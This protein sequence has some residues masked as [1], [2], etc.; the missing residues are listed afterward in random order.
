MGNPLLDI[1]AECDDKLYEKYGIKPADA[2][3]A[4]EKHM[5]IYAE[6]VAK[7]D[8]QYLAGG[9]TQNSIRV[10]QW[11]LPE[12]P[13]STAYMGCVGKDANAEQMKECCKKDGVNAVYM[14]D[15]A[16]PTGCC[17]VCI[18]GTERSMVTNLQAANNYKVD[19][20]KENW[21]VVE[22]A[23]I[24]YSAGF[25]VTVS[26][27]TI[28]EVS[29]HASENGKTYCFNLAAPFIMQV[30]PFKEVVMKTMPYIDFLFGNESEALVF[31]E[32]EGW[33]E[34]DIAEIA[35]KLSLLPKAKEPARTVV[36]TQGADP[37][38]VAI[39]GEVTTYPVL[40]LSKEM[41]K[42]TN[43]AGDA[44]VGGFLSGMVLKKDI[45][46]CARAGAYAASE[47]V[48]QSGCQFPEKPKFTW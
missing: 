20:A 11:M 23:Q 45:A 13:G 48:Q 35:K 1:S 15:A 34:K 29:K 32:T 16:T 8:V 10:C 3:L 18:L 6:M 17:A 41:L 33:E 27:E 30:P 31:A 24:F 2:I 38:I 22:S 9:A 7:P 37:T 47:V 40:A 12:N 36:I 46:D 28:A 21:S 43:G 14:E 19:H 25:F 44:Y 4:E 5:P 42:D 26:P 39:K